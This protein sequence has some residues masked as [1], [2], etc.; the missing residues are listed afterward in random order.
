M[1]TTLALAFEAPNTKKWMH[2]LTGLEKIGY[3]LIIT[4]TDK[5]WE[6]IIVHRELTVVSGPFQ[7][8]H[9]F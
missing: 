8:K 2:I 4:V 7:L 6:H 5:D 1:E 9:F 3:I